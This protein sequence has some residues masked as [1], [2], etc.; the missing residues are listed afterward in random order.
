M[1]SVVLV[2]LAVSAIAM[3]VTK[4]SLFSGLRERINCK[5]LY[6]PYCFSHW[7]ALSF[8]IPI[9]ISVFDWIIKSFAVVTIASIFSIGID[10]FMERI[11]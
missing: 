4:S 1:E 8:T 2:S 10:I 3:T 9:S 7:I 6:C 5:L 11:D